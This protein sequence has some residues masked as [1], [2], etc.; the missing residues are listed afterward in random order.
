MELNTKRAQRFGMLTAGLLL[1]VSAGLGITHNTV[2]ADTTS[3]S[4]ESTVKA[5]SSQIPYTAAENQNESNHYEDDVDA[6]VPNAKNVSDD[7]LPNGDTLKEGEHKV[8]VKYVL[9]DGKDITQDVN[10]RGDMAQSVA[11]TVDLG[12]KDGDK[13]DI[14][15]FALSPYASFDV[16][17]ISNGDGNNYTGK[18]NF[19]MP[20]H[21]VDVTV[22][23]APTGDDYV[24]DDAL[25]KD[26]KS[27]AASHPTD[28]RVTHQAYGGKTQDEMNAIW[29]ED[30]DKIKDYYNKLNGKTDS[31]SSSDTNKDSSSATSD[32]DNSSTD[33][34]NSGDDNSNTGSSIA[35]QITTDK[36]SSSSDSSTS[37]K[38]T[39]K[40]NIVYNGKSFGTVTLKDQTPGQKYSSDALNTLQSSLEKKGLSL[41]AE[42]KEKISGTVPDDDET[43]DLQVVSKDSGLST[44]GDGDDVNESVSSSLGDDGTETETGTTDSGD[45]DDGDTSTGDS[46]GDSDY[47]SPESDEE[48]DTG[49]SVNTPNEESQTGDDNGSS[50]EDS[51]N[52]RLPQTGADRKSVV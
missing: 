12:Y 50:S 8:T 18:E 3:E 20:D 46:T 52:S 15:N 34:T 16:V 13:V 39:L 7:E 31:N 21:N 47:D 4:D 41:S 38:V 49:D 25:T 9:P 43:Y 6:A 28:S 14:Y 11:E 23:I 10:Q 40:F 37:K 5:T 1:G 42:S 44:S 48:S 35:D 33:D 27:Y 30:A 32:D 22:T 45:M 36:G 2:H 29:Q 24:F 19:V 17:D 26:L 51:D